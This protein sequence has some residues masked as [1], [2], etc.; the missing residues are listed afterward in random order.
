MGL[1]YVNLEDIPV[2]KPGEDEDDS[3]NLDSKLPPSEQEKK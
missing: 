1:D 3:K 2:D